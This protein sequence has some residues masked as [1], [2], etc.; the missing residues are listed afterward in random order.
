MLIECFN[1]VVMVN[2]HGM[3]KESPFIS[4]KSIIL[5]KL[6]LEIHLIFFCE[7]YSIF[8]SFML[9]NIVFGLRK[10]KLVPFLQK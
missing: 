2:L 8:V 3:V 10:K 4:F 5:K 1:R 9:K 6:R 7:F